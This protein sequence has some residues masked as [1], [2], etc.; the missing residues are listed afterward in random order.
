M[1]CNG[2][3]KKEEGQIGIMASGT[4]ESLVVHVCLWLRPELGW[5]LR[6]QCL[7]C[8]QLRSQVGSDMLG[9]GAGGGC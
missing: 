2:A 8:G 9:M 4:P 7:L 3:W 5:K 1:V 6:S